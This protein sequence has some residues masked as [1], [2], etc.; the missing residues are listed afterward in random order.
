MSAV[1]LVLRTGVRKRRVQTIV[2]GLATVMAVTASVLGGA[3]LVVSSA[4]FDA[5]FAEQHGAHLSATFDPARVTPD[6]LTAAHPAGVTA[7]AGPYPAVTVTPQIDGRE[8]LPLNLVGRDT[9]DA[10]V[11]QL[12]LVKGKWA[13]APGEVVLSDAG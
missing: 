3:L 4:P 10:A 5:A 1:G 12:T 6:Q 7:T 9:P 11:D 2:I 8:S 13:H